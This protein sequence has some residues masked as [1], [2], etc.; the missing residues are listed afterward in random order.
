MILTIY[1]M[2]GIQS[3]I[4]ATNKMREMIGASV[5]VNQALFTNIP[6][7]FDETEDAWTKKPFTF[8]AG[9][10]HKIVYIGGGNALVVY[11]SSDTEEKY[12]RELQKMIF[13]QAG[14]AIR[15]CSASI[16]YDDSLS[17]ADNQKKL[18]EILDY[19]KRKTPNANTV[20]GFSINAHDNT[21]FE[22]ILLFEDKY[23]PRSKYLK[24][25]LEANI[26]KG[27]VPY[28]R[29]IEIDGIE[30]V[31]NFES[32]RQKEQKNYLAVIHLDGNTMGMRI[33][34]FVQNLPGE[35]KFADMT[36]LG[37]LS[38]EINT[39]YQDTMRTTIEKVYQGR[40]KEVPFRPVILDGD[41]VTVV[42]AAQ[43]AFLFISIFMQTLNEHKLLSLEE[44]GISANLTAGA[45]IAIVKHGFPFYTAY[46]IAEELCKSAKSKT[47]K[48][49]YEGDNSRSS[50]DF[51]ICYGGVTDSIEAFRERNYVFENYTLPRRPYI[52]NGKDEHKLFDFDKGFEATKNSIVGAIATNKLKGLR[53]AYGEGEMAAGI[54][55]DY[56]KSRHAGEPDEK[57]A[58]LL[59]EPFEE[60]N[61]TNYGIFFD[62][63]DLLDFVAPEL[64]E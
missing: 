16:E 48:L 63:L 50:V 32:F 60:Y 27:N 44:A 39:A 17:L 62:I 54:Y 40:I 22:P 51:H 49:G 5:I 47:L 11:D 19:N 9:D 23:A 20:G 24:L 30:Y 3:Y 29:S 10:K 52:F 43:D 25:E 28:F 31:R 13:N 15:L 6:H 38:A 35:D 18:M 64:E 42:C 55:G 45:G 53:Q 41:D 21:S 33:R 46:E 1:D 61:G 8:N 12:T 37:R 34:R 36:S 7:L 2:S 26:V 58:L 56:I 57:V 4:F 59:S 14:G